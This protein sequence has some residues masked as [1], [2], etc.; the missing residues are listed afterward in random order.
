MVL[1]G[2]SVVPETIGKKH[3]QLFGAE[4]ENFFHSAFR[5]YVGE[6]TPTEAARVALDPAVKLVERDQKVHVVA[7]TVPTG[8]DRIAD[9]ALAG[10]Y[11]SLPVDGIDDARIDADVAIVDTGTDANH[12]DLNVVSSVKCMPSCVSGGVDGY[13][14]GTH[15]GGIVGA[16]DNGIGAVGVA[17]GARPLVGQGP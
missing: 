16:L 11:A 12:P 1:R 3:E 5:G 13:G 7:Q 10:A 15:V 9:P 14:H 17:P 6:M 8:V 4:V 2:N